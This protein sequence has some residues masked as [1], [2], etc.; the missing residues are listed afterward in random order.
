M[1]TSFTDLKPDESIRDFPD[2]S[3]RIRKKKPP[4]LGAD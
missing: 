3:G 2:G 4:K 1:N